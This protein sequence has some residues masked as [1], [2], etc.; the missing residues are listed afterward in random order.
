MCVAQS[1]ILEKYILLLF[2]SCVTHLFCGW[3]TKKQPV[4][5]NVHGYPGSEPDEAQNQSASRISIFQ[6]KQQFPWQYTTILN[7]I[8]YEELYKYINTIEFG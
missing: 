1:Q 5:I 3:L 8:F 4:A 2:A 7:A 6:I